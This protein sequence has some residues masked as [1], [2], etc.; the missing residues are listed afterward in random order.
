[1]I[2]AAQSQTE[3]IKKQSG[4]T[5]SDIAVEKG[6]NHTIIYKY[7]YAKDPGI[8]IDATALKPTLVKGM[9]PVIDGI[10]AMVP[11]VKI[12]VIYLKPDKTELANI[13]ITQSDTDAVN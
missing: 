8:E 9:K 11:D 5:Y 13:L 1:M 2:S 3:Q 7:T 6:D 4:G 10:K 12:R